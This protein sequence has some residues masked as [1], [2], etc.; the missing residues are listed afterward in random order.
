M[1][2]LLHSMHLADAT[3]RT[4]C[5]QSKEAY[6]NAGCCEE[7]ITLEQ[8]ESTT[9]EHSEAIPKKKYNVM[10]MLIDDV[11]TERF[12][13]SGN[14]ALEGLLPGF[15]ELK[16]DGAIFYDH[17]YA[18]SSICAP[19]QASL[20][21]GMDPSR[22][23]AHNQFAGDN[24]EGL[25]KYKVTP[26]PEV[27][28]MPEILRQEGYWSTGAGKLDYQV[29]DVIPTFYNEITGGFLV[30]TLSPAVFSRFADPAVDQDR[31]FFS[32][33]NLMDV[34]QFLTA[35]QR[36]PPVFM[37]DPD[38]GAPP[39]LPFGK[40][41]YTTAA[42]LQF[43]NSG[44][45][46]YAPANS[47]DMDAVDIVG[48]RGTLDETKLTHANKG[49]PGYL[50]EDIGVASVLAKEYDMLRNLDYRLQKVIAKLKHLG[51][52]DDTL[53]MLFGDHGS[54]TYKAKVLMQLQ[55]MHTPVWIKL[56]KGMA[57]PSSVVRDSKGH[58]V[59]HQLAQL[60]DLLPTTL[61]VLGMPPPAHVDGRALLG[62]YA[63][64]KPPRDI[65][66]SSLSRLQSRDW[67]T[68]VAITKEY[69]YQV[70]QHQALTR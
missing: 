41:G 12:P 66:F 27:E 25:K 10:W 64:S 70:N 36:P 52:Y 11:S 3:V 69:V 20:F 40:M 14:G 62:P 8:K 51:V 30:D 34:H 39:N 15:D 13:E 35:M 54:G 48:Y 22:I 50:P 49:I 56:P 47:V 37:T 31:P 38:T 53:I 44:S 60:S 23:G 63:S 43:N 19:A 2:L 26:P 4:N 68:H 55:S 28:F 29:G 57:M 58:N 17:L 16:N 45:V 6:Q 59:D 5:V 67:K 1:A 21:S 7:G 46:Y 32:M 9:V 65:V 33:L 42:A 61:S 18:P 24:I